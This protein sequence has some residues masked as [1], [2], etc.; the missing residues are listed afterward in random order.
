MYPLALMAKWFSWGSILV[1]QFLL[2]C[3]QTNKLGSCGSFHRLSCSRGHCLLVLKFPVS[4]Q[5]KTAVNI[6]VVIE[7]NNNKLVGKNV[8]IYFAFWR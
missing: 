6:V 8:L 2:L 5:K 7:S 1:L 4:R 3:L